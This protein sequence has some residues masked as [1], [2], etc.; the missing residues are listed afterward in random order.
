MTKELIIRVNYVKST[1][2]E[3]ER[4]YKTTV[5][6]VIRNYNRFTNLYKKI[7]LMCD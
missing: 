4:W 3:C 7:Y 6:K 5:D 1:V 2:C